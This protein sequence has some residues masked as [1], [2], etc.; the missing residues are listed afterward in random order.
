MRPSGGGGKS[1]RGQ[2]LGHPRA[3]IQQLGYC[4][5][6]PCV[7]PGLQL[8]DSGVRLEA[9]AAAEI[10]RQVGDHLVRRV[11]QRPVAGVEEHYLFLDPEGERWGGNAPAP[12]GPGGR[13]EVHWPKG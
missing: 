12:C 7:D 11:G 13:L 9:Y 1:A 6:H 2:D 5:A 10:G 8:D 4:V 3:E